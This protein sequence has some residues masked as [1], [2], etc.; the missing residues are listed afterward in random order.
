MIVVIEKM[1]IVGVREE[2]AED[3]ERFGRMICYG[4]SYKKC[5]A[6]RGQNRI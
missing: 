6:E 4:D 1:Q 2:F 3:R 5:K